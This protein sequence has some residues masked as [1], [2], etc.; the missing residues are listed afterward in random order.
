MELVNSQNVFKPYEEAPTSRV[1]RIQYQSNEATASSNQ[2]TRIRIPHSKNTFIDTSRS[3]LKF[4]ATYAFVGTNMNVVSSPLRLSPVGGASHIS[5]IYVRCGGREIN[6]FENYGQIVGLLQ[7]SN[8][9]LSNG[10]GYSLIDH[11]SDDN[12][13]LNEGRILTYDP[14]TT[15]TNWT[16][17]MDFGISLMGLLGN[18]HKHLATGLLSSDIEISIRWSSVFAPI[19]MEKTVSTLTSG[20]CNY[21]NVVYC[22]KVLTLSES[23]VESIT[24]RCRDDDGIMSWSGSNWRLDSILPLQVAELT[25]GTRVST[26]LNGFRYKSLKSIGVAGF[27]L[28]DTKHHTAQQAPIGFMS[29]TRNAGRVSIAG[30]YYPQT[31]LDHVSQVVGTTNTTFSSASLATTNSTFCRSGV[32]TGDVV[33]SAGQYYNGTTD[34]NQRPNPETTHNNNGNPNTALVINLEDSE[35]QGSAGINSTAVQST[36]ECDIDASLASS[37]ARGV[38]SACF[39][40]HHDVIYSINGDGVLSVSW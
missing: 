39:F 20:T 6:A 5:A 34:L 1:D 16:G 40:S 17:S 11:S 8:T 37:Y 32:Y 15:L 7:G 24:R 13:L 30:K 22:A 19:Y 14:T 2:T 25:S 36:F 3:I 31:P 18:P 35:I 26:I 33:L 9:S 27:N 23:E 28:D 29:G 4:K 21:T 10:T 12:K 38:V